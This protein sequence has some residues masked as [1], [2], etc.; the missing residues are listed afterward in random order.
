MTDKKKN[1]LFAVVAYAIF[2]VLL[3]ASV[4]IFASNENLFPK[5]MAFDQIVGTWAPTFAL[6]IL[7]K[8]LYPDWT[9]GAF[10]RNAFKERLNFKLLL[11]VTVA[12]LVITA[13]I[14]GVGAF[15]QKVSFFSLLNFTF[16]G[17]LITLFSGAMGEESGWRGYLQQ[18][19]EKRHSL[20]RALLI[21]GIIWAFWHVPTWM[22]YITGGMP[23]LIPLDILDKIALAFIIGICYNRCRNLLVP[24]WIHFVANM[25]VNG[26]QGTL[27]DYYVWY[28]LLEVLIAAGYI[29]W[30]LKSGK[31]TVAAA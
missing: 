23:Y 31:N 7:F 24:M 28:V 17:F 18:S 10:F 15:S 6:L 26:T 19:V 27:I 16:A 1:I 9:V 12:L 21:V 14:V 2:W 3:I 13:G 4:I 30:Y 25:V 22:N 11:V 20:L 29:V 8:K 5:V